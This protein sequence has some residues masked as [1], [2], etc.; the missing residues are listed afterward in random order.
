MAGI[1]INNYKIEFYPPTAWPNEPDTIQK[2]K[3]PPTGAI[4]S[5]EGYTI[6]SVNRQTGV[7]EE[8]GT[9]TTNK[10]GQNSTDITGT[11]KVTEQPAADPYRWRYI[12]GIVVVTVLAGIA[13]WFG[14]RKCEFVA[15]VISFVKKLF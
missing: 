10:T 3:L 9:A 7:N 11:V 2:N 14:L 5:I 13:A 6:K 12:F 4:K 15:T 1:E 8:K